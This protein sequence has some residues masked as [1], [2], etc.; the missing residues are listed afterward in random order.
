MNVLVGERMS[1]I[2]NKPQTTRH[3]IIGIVN[4]E[5][6]QIVFSDTPGLI[7]EPAYK[8]Q[9]SMHHF[10]VSTFADADLM[11]FMTDT[12]EAPEIHEKLQGRLQN[13]EVP[14]IVLINKVDLSSQAKVEKSIANWST[15]FP[16]AR[17]LPISALEKIGIDHLLG[18][19]ID[20]LAEGPEYYPKDQLTDKSERFFVSEIIREKIL[21]LYHQEIPY[22]TQV[23][24][25]QFKEGEAKKGKI[26]RISAD[27]IVGRKSQKSIIIGR[28]GEKIKRLGTE[29]R[30][31]I[32]VFLEEKVFLEL[33]VKVKENWRDDERTL[34]YFGY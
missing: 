33:R 13:L 22:S 5:N 11:L 18:L 7:S 10:A 16:K 8:M 28:A 20:A 19:I 2:T 31:D 17:I 23:I 6:Y 4:G 21:L 9:E 25:D 12:L 29:A 1:I 15:K 34:K 32:E 14:L 24:I 26:I 3:R 27:I 30:K